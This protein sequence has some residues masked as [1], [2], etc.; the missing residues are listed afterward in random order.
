[1]NSR[2][3][4]LDQFRGYTVVGMLLVNFGG[5]FSALP[6]VLKHHNTYCSYADTIMPQFFFAVGFALRLVLLRNIEAL[7]AVAAYRRTLRRIG[8]LVLLGVVFYNLNTRWLEIGGW[9]DPLLRELLVGSFWR[10]SFQTLVHIGVTCLW[11]LPFI[12]KPARMRLLV[13]I[14]SGLVHL[15]LSAWFWYGMLHEKRV[16]DGGPLGFLTWTL[17]VVAGSFAYDWERNLGP[18]GAIR[19]LVIWGSA[20]MVGGYA[21]SCF[22]SGGPLTAL[23]FFPPGGGIDLW[24]MSQRAGSLSYLLFASGFSMVVYV[25]FILACD[26][27]QHRLALFSVFGRNA[28]T[29]YILHEVIGIAFSTIGQKD[30]PL[31]IAL[32]VIAAYIGVNAL[33]LAWLSR[34]KWVLRL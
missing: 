15:G 26:V 16:I 20:A 14:I 22:G 29:A 19:P 33:V 10:T 3:E 13:A 12:A 6:A 18:R 21:L 34:R 17:P 27:G 11:L 8:M 32:L 24:T 28:L 30:A 23:P 5:G 2:I 7:G 25:L 9:R 1:M 31:S 4:S